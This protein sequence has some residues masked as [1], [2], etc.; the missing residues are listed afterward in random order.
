MESY[1]GKYAGVIRRTLTALHLLCI[2]KK[3]P[4]LAH[5]VA[6]TKKALEEIPQGLLM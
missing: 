2:K 6:G 1:P 5:N 4:V 3:R